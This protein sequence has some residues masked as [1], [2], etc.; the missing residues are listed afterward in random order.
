VLIDLL[1][2]L[3][4]GALRLPWRM[5]RSGRGRALAGLAC[6]GLL[7]IA[8]NVLAA[9]ALPQ[10]FDLTADGR[11]TLSA[12]TTRTL[13]RI[14][15]PITLRLYYSSQLGDALPADGVYEERVRALLDQYVAAA[16]GKLRLEARDPE[17]HSAVEA[18]AL[19]AGLQA[20]PLGRQNQPGFFGLVG[21]N[22]TDDRVTI[23][24][25]DPARERFLEFDLTRLVYVLAMPNAAAGA[26]ADLAA[27]R[28]HAAAA[29]LAPAAQLE[30]AIEVADIGLMPLLATG[31]A[32]VAA[33]RRRSAAMG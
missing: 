20:V 17:P 21:T 25:F 24:F 19:A 11:Y 30:T 8:A 27:L 31:A 29:R 26:D 33:R 15:E 12:A 2:N 13:A 10:R 28:R 1:I 18:A 9:T 32:L 16:R 7:V 4:R 5:Y 6:I 23:A 22:S 14:D 3:L